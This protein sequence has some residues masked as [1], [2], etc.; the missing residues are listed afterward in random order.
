VAVPT[1]AVPTVAV[2]TAAVPSLAVPSATAPSVAAPT[3]SLEASPLHPIEGASPSSTAT[4]SPTPSSTLRAPVARKP[5]RPR[6]PAVR[7]AT[8]PLELPPPAVAPQPGS[9]PR[10]YT[11]FV[12]QFGPDDDSWTD[13][14]RPDVGP[15]HPPPAVAAPVGPPL[16]R[17][18]IAHRLIVSG[19]AGLV[20]ALGGL[21]F[22]VVR[23]R[24]W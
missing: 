11:P 7:R 13:I 19:T 8:V 4:A 3:L 17:A 22:V 18:A 5:D 10:V 14:V 2:P 24:R 16:E 1:V 12:P 9:V 15:Q 23:R 21:A 20:L 6:Q